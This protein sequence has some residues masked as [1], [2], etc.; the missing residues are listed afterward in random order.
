MTL[1]KR[2]HEDF[3]EILEEDA[4]DLILTHGVFFSD[5]A[6][7]ELCRCH[8]HHDR[9]KAEKDCHHRRFLILKNPIIEMYVD[10]KGTY[11]NC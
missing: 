8:G 6:V 1:T 10:C 7:I 11:I 2:N 5:G 4:T 9:Q 3:N